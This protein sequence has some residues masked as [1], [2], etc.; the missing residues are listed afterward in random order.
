MASKGEEVPAADD[1][2][3]VG[4]DP[5]AEDTVVVGA[6]E[7]TQ[8]DDDWPVA[9]MYR[10]EPADEGTAATTPPPP[11]D[12]V[13]AQNQTAPVPARRGWVPE[14]VGVG[15]M[16]LIAGVIGVLILLG[17]FLALRDDDEPATT[18]TP[19]TT[20]PAETTTGAQTT[21]TPSGQLTLRD[22]KGMSLG[23]ARAL[24]EKQ[25]LR[26]RVS[27]LQADQLRNEVLTQAPPAGTK[28]QRGDEVSLVVSRGPTPSAPTSAPVPGV[29]GLS[30]SDAVAAI[31]DAGFEPR[32]RLVTSSQPAGTVLEQKPPEGTDAE[33]GSTVE[34]QVA[35]ARAT[36]TAQR[37]EVPDV[38]GLSVSTARRELRSAG[39]SVTV[40]EVASEGAAGTV[41][42]Q[43]P[44]AG[45]GLRKG[46]TVTLR[47]STGPTKLDVPDVT[48]LDE[49]SARAELEGAGFQVQVID[50]S[51]TDPAQDGVVLRQSPRGGSSAAESAMVTLTVG[52]L[53]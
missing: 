47:V 5:A 25:G 13:V 48:G 16:L 3:V 41:V 29:V 34:L 2:V 20:T 46:G 51:V 38:V 4:A 28:I 24:L 31:R 27:R 10:V 32:T 53:G 7:V 45:A 22:L 42:S 1:T 52:R 11:G 26:V 12:I 37:I 19:I 35:K 43:S 44:R 49:Q 30:A 17:A 50:E 23:E 9:D 36:P 6:E 40:V 8:A 18:D 39:L 33:K 14:D 21:A 15:L